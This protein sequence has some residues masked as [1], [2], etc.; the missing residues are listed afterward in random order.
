MDKAGA[1]K[2]VKCDEC[3]WNE[4]LLYS[5]YPTAATLQLLPYSWYPTAA[6]LQLVPYTC[7]PTPGTLQLL[8]YSWY[9]TAGTLQLLLYSCYPTAATLQAV[10]SVKA[11]GWVTRTEG[12]VITTLNVTSLLHFCAIVL[13]L[14]IFKSPLTR[15]QDTNTQNGTKTHMDK[16]HRAVG[17]R[18]QVQYISYTA[19]PVETPQYHNKC[20]P[21]R[22]QPNTSLRPTHPVRT[23]RSARLHPQTSIST[24][25]PSQPPRGNF[26]PHNTHQETETTPDN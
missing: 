7:Y 15:K 1:V 24:G 11:V 19:I 2:C 18:Q 12:K 25:I 13:F 8:P 20:A 9:P 3:D 23:L 6:T 14:T 22:N 21:V 10:C 26:N 5:W 16:R 17:L 4:L